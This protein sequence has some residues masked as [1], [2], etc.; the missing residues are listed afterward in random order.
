MRIS[1]FVSIVLVFLFAS[2]AKTRIHEHEE[3]GKIF[4]AHN[5]NTGCFIVRD[6]THD[7]LY[8]FNK[9]QCL[10]RFL[11]ASTFKIFN[12]LVSLETAVA[13]DDQLLIKWDSVV[14]R[15]EWNKDMNMREAFKTSCVPYYQEL[16]RRVGKEKFQFYLDTTRYGNKNCGGAVDMF[17]LNDSLQISAD[18]Q[19]GFIK[20]LYFDELPFSER[21][22]RIVRS[23]MLWEDKPEYK[24]YYKTG[25]GMMKDSTIYWVV[26]YAEKIEH[27]KE[28]ANSMNKTDVRNYPY[29]FAQNF[30]LPNSDTS[31]NW[32][33]ERLQ[34]M[35]E[36]LQSIQA[37]SK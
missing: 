31:K 6:H 8:Y 32:F 28:H 33:S 17:W 22:Q 5:I 26:G 2:C 10:S 9:E 27:V 21:S 16:A 35:H 36:M 7:A 29:F 34:I 4:K 1:F 18:E 15:S 25:T 13:A 23:L 24:L 30:V 20:R 19:V 14:R 37:V 3:F 11:P 12:S